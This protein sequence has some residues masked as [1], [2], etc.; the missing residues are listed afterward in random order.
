MTT[1]KEAASPTKKGSNDG[2]GVVAVSH[3][4]SRIQGPARAE[5][6]P[7]QAHQLLTNR[8]KATE[9]ESAN[10]DIP[11]GRPPWIVAC[12]TSPNKY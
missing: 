9:K 11:V 3:A 10:E 5:L 4:A 7:D 12:C 8:Q 6:E 1:E 2:T